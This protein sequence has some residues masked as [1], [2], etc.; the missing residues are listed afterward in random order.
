MGCENAAW[1][2][3]GY[4]DDSTNTAECN[5]DDGDCCG[6]NVNMQ[7]C[8]ECQ[9]HRSSSSHVYTIPEST[10]FSQNFVCFLLLQGK[11]FLLR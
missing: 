8:T 11:S 7:Y 1:A 2:G 9:C 5:F 3:D 6:G 4:C 10:I